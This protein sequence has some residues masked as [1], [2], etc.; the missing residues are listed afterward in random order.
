MSIVKIE[1]GDWLKNAA[2]VGFLKILNKKQDLEHKVIIKSNYIEFD[3]A[4]LEGFEEEYFRTLVEENEKNI[5]WYKLV[6]MESIINNIEL[7]E[8]EIKDIDTLN[9]IIDDF[10]NKLN[11]NS[12]K[13]AY[14]ILDDTKQ[15]QENE[16]KLA[17]IKLKKK[18]SIEEVKEDIK[19]QC[20]ILNDIIEYLRQQE[21]KRVIAAKNVMYDIVQPFWTNVSFLLKT[22]NQKDMYTLYK[23][24]FIDTAISYIESD[25]SKN[26]YYCFTCDNK[27]SKF[28]KPEAYDLTWLVKTGADMSRK[29]SHFWNMNGDA[30]IC[31]I[32]NLLYSCLPLGFISIRGKGIFINNNHTVKS[33]VD[34]N[35][36][37]IQD[38]EKTFEEIE[39]LSYLN[40]VNSMEQYNVENFEKEFEN[41]QVV[42]IDG[43]NGSRPYTF[44]VLS[45]KLMYIIYKNRKS[46]N[47]LIKIRVKISDKYYLN[48]Y[49]EVVRRLYDSKN[50]FDIISQLLFLNLNGKFKGTYYIYKILEINNDVIGE[51]KM[52]YKDTQE[53]KNYGLKLRKAYIE[54]NSKS[55]L[56]GITY[57]LLNALKTKDSSKFMDTLI[58][59]YM[60]MKSEIPT[61]F[62][63]ALSNQEVFQGIGYA[64]LIGFQGFDETKLNNS[65]NEEAK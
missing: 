44:N 58:N 51:V 40:I 2:I 30:Y 32:C 39:Q 20:S 47:Q 42:K 24:D 64:F 5:S 9:N 13:N 38:P 17:K 25:K 7:K 33:L 61:G 12:Y 31:P 41:V 60:Y 46:L 28:S 14:L 15:I 65:E 22:N 3:T 59:S 45:K 27:I 16:K 35:S 11:S 43:N 50:L 37:K 48:L 21:V 52:N 26:K 34:S 1:S 56:S 18:Q 53:F 6:S 29:S 57:R 55:K 63:K 10:K 36:I 4:M 8:N 62:V 54:K 23:S 49:D 19:K